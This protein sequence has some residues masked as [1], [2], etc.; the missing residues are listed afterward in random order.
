VISTGTSSNINVYYNTV[1][2]NPLHQY[3]WVYYTASATLLQQNSICEITYYNNSTG[4][5]LA[6]AFVG[7]QQI[8]KIMLLLRIIIYSTV[9][10]MNVG[11]IY[12]IS[13]F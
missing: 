3:I 4:S 11:T 2:L 5:G 8:C 9:H 6:V 7:R 10:L 12:N 13:D 1:Y